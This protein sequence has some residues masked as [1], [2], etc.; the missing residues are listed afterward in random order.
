MWRLKGTF[1]GKTNAGKVADCWPP[2]EGKFGKDRPHADEAV[3][4]AEAPFALAHHFQ[5]ALPP[6]CPKVTL[7]MTMLSYLARQSEKKI[8]LSICLRKNW[9]AHSAVLRCSV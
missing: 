3:T 9:L 2:L 5:L 8:V 6:H 7:A 1:F 4:D